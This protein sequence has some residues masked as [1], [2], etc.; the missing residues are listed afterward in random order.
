[1]QKFKMRVKIKLNDG[2][3]ITAFIY[4][5]RGQRVQD[6]LNDDRMFIPILHKSKD[7]RS[8]CTEEE[9]VDMVLSKNA[10]LSVEEAES[11]PAK[12]VG[13]PV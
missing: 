8:N 6:I 11:V 1:M 13:F 2:S 10:I 7:V 5:S 3:S 9:H 12:V 4:L